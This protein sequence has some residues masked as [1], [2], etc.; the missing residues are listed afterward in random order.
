M[1]VGYSRTKPTDELAEALR[2]AFAELEAAKP[3]QPAKPRLIVRQAG[4]RHERR[5]LAS[6][7]RRAA[8]RAVRRGA[9]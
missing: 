9:K 5:R 1:G 4:N 8:R 6:L 2:A 3:K 7:N